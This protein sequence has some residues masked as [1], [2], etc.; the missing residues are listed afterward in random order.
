MDKQTLK[1]EIYERVEKYYNQRVWISRIKEN[2]CKLLNKEVPL[3]LIKEILVELSLAKKNSNDLSKSLERNDGWLKNMVD[4][5]WDKKYYD[6]VQETDHIVFYPDGNPYPVL[7]TTALAMVESYSKKWKNWS[8]KKMMYEFQLTPKA[9]NYIKT[10]LDMYK[11]SVP[12]DKVT[13]SLMGDTWEMESEAKKTAERLTE[14]KMSWIY[15]REI[16]NIEKRIIKNAAINNWTQLN[17]LNNLERV[18]K[19]YKPREFSK[20][21]IPEIKN[22]KTKSIVFW[23]A[24]LWKKWTDGIVLRFKKI[25]RELVECEEKNIEITFLWDIWECFLPFPS[26]MHPDQR[27]WMEETS[28]EELVMLAVDV[29]EQMLLELYNAWKNVTFNWLWWNHWRITERKE[30]DPY[31]SAEMIIYRFI[32]KIVENTNIKINILREQINIIKSQN[33]KYIFMHWDELTPQKLQRI[34]VQEL[35]WNYYLCIVSWDKHHLKIQEIS[36]RVIRIQSPALSWKWRFDE[37]LALSSQSWYIELIKNKDW[38]I[39]VNVKR[40]K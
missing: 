6:Y 17:F 14:A 29:L 39:D 38:L 26:S 25:T 36:D 20:T 8:W 23:D 32:Q 22:N 21:N 33:I 2:I 30:F 13:L 9:W 12:F 4:G 16:D 27:L 24:H 35:E 10:V 19:L 1:S 40:I 37:G 31:R 34:V 3:E 15:D 5:V 11:D 7:R 28:T 18:I